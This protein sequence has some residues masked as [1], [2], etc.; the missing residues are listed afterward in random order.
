MHEHGVND[1]LLG[2]RQE[3]LVESAHHDRRVLGEVH[4]LSEGLRRK[5][6][7]QT[8]LLLRRANLFANALP[9]ARL[10][11]HDIGA[12]K[13]IDQ[14]VGMLDR[15]RA[16]SQETMTAGLIARHEPRET[17]G[18]DLVAQQ[19]DDPTDRTGEVLARRAPSQ[20]FGHGNGPR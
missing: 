9:R 20:D 11:W 12:A 19:S 10:R 6:G 4:D 17:H 16:G 5:L 1:D 8:D 15:M 14:V 3:Q 13:H 7:G 18:N 2:N